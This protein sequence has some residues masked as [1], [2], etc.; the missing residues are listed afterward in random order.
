MLIVSPFMY[1]QY[2]DDHKWLDTDHKKLLRIKIFYL[3]Y[4]EKSSVIFELENCLN[5][6]GIGLSMI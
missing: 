1:I 2:R 5:F 4:Y 3:P 6:L